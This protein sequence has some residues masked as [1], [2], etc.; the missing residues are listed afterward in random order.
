MKA[1]KSFT[2]KV[3]AFEHLL[4]MAVEVHRG[5]LHAPGRISRLVAVLDKSTGQSVEG[6]RKKVKIVKPGSVARV[7]VEVEEAVPL[8][9][10]G[11]VVLRAGGE[12][13]G[14]GLLE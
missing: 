13:V 3:L 9:V 8:E 6:A 14:A 1:V 2:V 10:G 5:R 11:R 4:P 12:T 7:V